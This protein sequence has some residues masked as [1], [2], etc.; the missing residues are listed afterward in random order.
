M[1]EKVSFMGVWCG[2]KN[3]LLG[4]TVRRH[5]A[6]LVMPIS[7]PRDRFFYPHHTTMKDTYCPAHGTAHTRH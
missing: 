6:S 5:S 7:D 3:L 1:Q 4:I 2:Y